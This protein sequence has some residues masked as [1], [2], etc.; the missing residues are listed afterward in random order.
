MISL[1]RGSITHIRGTEVILDLRGFGLVLE[2]TVPHAEELS[3]GTESAFVTRF[4]VKEN[5]LAL[6]GFR[7]TVELDLFARLT[8]VPGI[9]PKSAMAAL[10][11]YRSDELN[12]AIRNAN[13]GAFRP[14]PGIGPKTAALIVGSLRPGMIAST[15]RDDSPDERDV[16]NRDAPFTIGFQRN[17]PGPVALGWN[18]KKVNVAVQDAIRELESNPAETTVPQLLRMALALL[19]TIARPP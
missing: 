18:K 10:S 3:V 4:S 6:Y 13:V 9:G 12:K 11:V 15:A 8:A 7:D 16:P 17:Q 19:G 14:V 5:S 2:V 1:L